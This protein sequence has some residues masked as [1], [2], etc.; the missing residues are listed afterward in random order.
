MF[1]NYLFDLKEGLSKPKTQNEKE[2][3][4]LSNAQPY[5]ELI[6]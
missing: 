6:R 2:N 1:I 5:L 4:D 3:N